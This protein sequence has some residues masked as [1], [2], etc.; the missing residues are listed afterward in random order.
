MLVFMETALS[1]QMQFVVFTIF[2]TLKTLKFIEAWKLW[3]VWIA[4]ENLIK[5]EAIQ[6]TK[7]DNS[8][9]VP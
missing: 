7:M 4:I 8:P 6:M 9:I 1:K 2:D 5:K 3:Q